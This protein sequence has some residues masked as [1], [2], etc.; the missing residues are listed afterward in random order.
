[1]RKIIT[2]F[3][4]VLLL[5]ITPLSYLQPHA[6][7]NTSKSAAG[8]LP[9]VFTAASNTAT[10]PAF[11]A[12][13]YIDSEGWIHLV[14]PDSGSKS[15]AQFM[16][17]EDGPSFT[18]GEFEFE[19]KVSSV[20]SDYSFTVFNRFSGASAGGIRQNPTFS[21]VQ[22]MGG[23]RWM[24]QCW[25]PGGEKYSGIGLPLLNGTVNQNVI[26][27]VKPEV[28]LVRLLF[29]GTK[30]T[31]Y[32]DG[33]QQGEPISSGGNLG[34]TAGIPIIAGKLGF[35][36]HNGN[37]KDFMLRNIRI[38][39]K[40]Q[41]G[42][43][44]Y[45]S[46]SAMPDPIPFTITTAADS[47][48]Q[49]RRLTMKASTKCVN[50]TVTG[51]HPGTSINQAGELKVA[52]DQPIGSRLTVTASLWSHPHAVQTKVIH[53]TEQH[54]EAAV[55]FGV[56]SDLHVGTADA[57][58]SSYPNH[59][60]LAD[61]LDW[62]GRRNVDAVLM[63][64][65][66]SDFGRAGDWTQFR[67]VVANRL[68]SPQDPAP[69]MPIMVAA[70][71]NHDAYGQ[72]TPAFV[73]GTGQKTNADYLI[74]GYHFITV[75]GGALLSGENA[76]SNS[77][78]FNTAG[79]SASTGNAIS[80]ETK[81]WLRARINNAKSEDPHKPIFILCHWPIRNT[82][83]V[84]DEWYTES[85]GTNDT[86]YFFKDDPQVVVFSGHIHS[87][88][89]DPR[90]IWQ[91]G[92]TSVNTG[93]LHYMEMEA[94]GTANQRY[95]GYKQDGVSTNSHPRNPI[96]VTAEEN[97]PMMQGLI[98][99][100]DGSRVTIRNYD[101]DATAGPAGQAEETEQVWSFDVSAPSSFPYTNA[102]RNTNRQAPIFDAAQGSNAAVTGKINLSFPS[103]DT[104]KVAIT[105]PQAKMPLFN[106]G[107][108]VVHS[109]KFEFWNQATG[110]LA[111]TAWQWSDFMWP[112]RLQQESCTQLIGGLTANV[113]YELRIY[114]FGSF[115][116]QSSQYLTTAFTIDGGIL[117][118]SLAYHLT[119][120]NTLTNLLGNPAAVESF[121][122]TNPG[123]INS[124]V[125][126]SPVYVNGLSGRKALHLA[127]TISGTASNYI[128]LGN[129]FN[130]NQSFT[131]AFH[132]FLKNGFTTDSAIFS[133]KNWG[134]GQSRGL[135]VTGHNNGLRV[136]VKTDGNSRADMDLGTRSETVDRW[137]HVAVVFRKESNYVDLYLNGV[138]K[139]HLNM[140]L[141]NGIDGGFHTYIGQTVEP[142]GQ[143]GN[144]RI[145]NI[146]F[147][148]SDFI[149]QPGAMSDSM[150]QAL[151]L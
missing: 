93:S 81:S 76:G 118:P 57:S 7:D 56:L 23:G 110:A 40:G 130:Y 96:Q 15:L 120:N 67:S 65:D 122:T 149:L 42:W 74:N 26:S 78:G 2:A 3:L 98:V 69:G 34:G 103:N 36:N 108:E 90:S 87:P 63:G 82:F 116:Q 37:V 14:S 102:R 12:D 92:F 124:S 84:S 106:S 145:Y 125:H 109:Y 127:S 16:W 146:D 126:A 55:T 30:T 38:R 97:T 99:E 62:Y 25:G 132:I 151:A 18:D 31:I 72:G 129:T 45:G 5:I 27:M 117:P 140:D 41:T 22:Y 13:P 113:P 24:T 48:E 29:E 141:S 104:S 131:L 115:Q 83:Y 133:N 70:M 6:A 64:G 91:G 66:I 43:Q 44:Y 150:I 11:E 88:N 17:L 71:G 121:W 46:N 147:N 77:V 114:A 135:L 148:I 58:S 75:N 68:T 10:S 19:W 39:E 51:G 107:N 142:A 73:Q 61:V 111:K 105:F 139:H 95:L 112:Q 101:F 53:V 33:V 50:W 21:G 143:F 35:R 134:A 94:S 32:I 86:N 47:V 79:S 137:A 20:S 136:I 60:R 28:H 85:F 119:F 4:A 59:Q 128:D 123:N 89:Q 52:S 80:Q 144:G 100:A 9:F 1:M 49:D 8:I 138:R 54:G